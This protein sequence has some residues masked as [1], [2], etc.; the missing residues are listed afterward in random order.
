MADLDEFLCER[1]G[2][3]H[4]PSWHRLDDSKNI[5]PDELE[6]L[7]RCIG[8]DVDNPPVEGGCG[9]PDFIAPPGY[10]EAIDALVS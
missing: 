5:G 1:E 7:F 3:H 2:C 8:Y 6:A 10:D 4:P 9:C